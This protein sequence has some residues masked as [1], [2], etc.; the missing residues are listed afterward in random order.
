MPLAASVS[1]NSEGTGVP[2]PSRPAGTLG[3]CVGRGG[4][5]WPRGL[6]K[7]RP[8]EFGAS[9]PYKDICSASQWAAGAA[10]GPVPGRPPAHPSRAGPRSARP[11]APRRSPVPA[12]SS[13]QFIKGPSYGLSAEVRNRVSGRGARPRTRGASALT[14]QGGGRPGKPAGSGVR[15]KGTPLLCTGVPPAAPPLDIPH[16]GSPGALPAPR[17]ARRMEARPWRRRAGG[18]REDRPLRPCA[19]QPLRPATPATPAPRDPRVPCAPRPPHPLRPLRVP[20][21]APRA[22]H[23]P[24]CPPRPCTPAPCDP[25]PATPCVVPGDTS[26]PPPPAT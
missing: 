12:M 7:P 10:P 16:P 25:S 26:P 11:S 13:T 2:F 6:R 1:P 15:E 5:R 4:P 23:A 8:Q 20:R 21:P 19:Q 24:L 18:V 17:A 9:T 3:G 14:P 22:S